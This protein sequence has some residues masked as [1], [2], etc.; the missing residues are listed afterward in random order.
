M[1]RILKK[2]GKLVIIDIFKQ[3][4][5]PNQF[6]KDIKQNIIGGKKLKNFN[7]TIDVL[8]GFLSE[9]GFTNINIRNL[10]KSKNVKFSHLCFFHFLSIFRNMRHRILEKFGQKSHKPLVFSWHFFYYFLF[11]YL[12]V[13]VCRYRYFSIVTNKK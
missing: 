7:V 3:N 5:L 12:L 9:E 4:D 8:K 10:I 11:K 2:N 1:Y 13:I 6:C